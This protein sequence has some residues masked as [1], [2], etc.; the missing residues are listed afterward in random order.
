MTSGSC[1]LE[2]L[3][4]QQVHL[5]LT[6]ATSAAGLAVFDLVPFLG[7]FNESPV[8]SKEQIDSKLTSVLRVRIEYNP[9]IAKCEKILMSSLEDMLGQS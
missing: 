3:Q 2:R 9:R 5:L 1:L 4:I 7:A 6:R 8:T